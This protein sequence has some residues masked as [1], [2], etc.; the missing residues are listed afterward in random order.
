[1]SFNRSITF[2]TEITN[3]IIVVLVIAILFEIL[4]LFP[5]KKKNTADCETMT[6]PEQNNSQI[7]LVNLDNLITSTTQKTTLNTNTP[8]VF[9]VYDRYAEYRENRYSNNQQKQNMYYQD[10]RDE[11]DVDVDD[12]DDVDVETRYNR[13]IARSRSRSPYS[14]NNT[15]AYYRSRL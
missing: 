9:R 2:I 1:M 8:T 5:S 4:S 6:E 11:V 14:P 13:Q 3:T 12:V 7:K 10:A 15:S